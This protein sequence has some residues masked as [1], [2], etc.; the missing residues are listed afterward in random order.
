MTDSLIDYEV[1]ETIAEIRLN[2]PPV[3]ALSLELV[4]ALIGALCRAGEDDAVRAV[5]LSSANPKVFC[6]GLDL[7]LVRGRPALEFRRFLERLYMELYDVQYRLGKPSIAAVRGAARAGG[8]TVML[9]CDMVVAGEGASFG[10]PE[11]DVGLVPGLHLVH[12]P[13][14]AGRYRAFEPLFT[15]EPFDAATAMELGLLSRLV[16]DE[17]VADT[18]RGLA[19]T[20]AAKPP[21]ILRLGREA[22]MRANDLDYR[23]GFEQ[24]AETMTVIAGSEDCQEGLAA[25]AEKRKPRWTGR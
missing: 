9:S 20:L 14:V 24:V 23:R 21:E 1:R 11:I 6:A 10:Y 3:N 13:R 22:F 8:M 25:F 17:A 7:D 16:A 5:I 2:R 12:L 15:G 4:E 19:E 18:A